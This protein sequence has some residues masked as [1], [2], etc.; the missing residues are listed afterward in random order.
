MI[1]GHRDSPVEKYK[2][3]SVLA[4]EL[5]VEWLFVF[6]KVNTVAL[7]CLPRNSD[8]LGRAQ[9]GSFWLRVRRTRLN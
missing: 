6:S 3:A 9:T 8:D 4:G 5:A 2:P 7:G 1:A